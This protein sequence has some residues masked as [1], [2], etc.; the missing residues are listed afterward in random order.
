MP[1]RLQI[2]QIKHIIVQFVS[3]ISQSLVLI[4]VKASSVD[5]LDLSFEFYSQTCMDMRKGIPFSVM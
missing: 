3:P 4:R 2:R 5:L 1:S